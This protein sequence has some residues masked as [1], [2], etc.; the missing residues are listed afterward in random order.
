LKP[1]PAR[2]GWQPG[3]YTLV[4]GSASARAEWEALAD[5]VPDAAKAA[6]ERLTSEPLTRRPKRQFPLRG[7]AQ[8][9][10]WELEVTGADRVWYAV[11]LTEM[12][13]VV[14]CSRKLHTAAE[15]TKTIEKRRGAFDALPEPLPPEPVR[16]EARIR[17]NR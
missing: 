17:R 6:F 8:K 2:P 14:A 13:V 5:R 15:L 16:I 7:H 4:A 9:P 3:R 1:I 12:T 10:F 11:S